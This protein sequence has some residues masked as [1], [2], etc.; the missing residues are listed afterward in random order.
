MTPL[1]PSLLAQ[2]LA[3]PADDAPRVEASDWLQENGEPEFGEFIGVQV[4]IAATESYPGDRWCA[5]AGGKLRVGVEDCRKCRPCLLRHRERELLPRIRTEGVFYA[6]QE[7]FGGGGCSWEY[8]RGFVANLTLACDD[9]MRHAGEIFAAQPVEEVTLSDRWPWVP[10]G[11]TDHAVLWHWQKRSTRAKYVA[12]D[13][14]VPWVLP[15]EIAAHL[16]LRTGDW[17]DHATEADALAA[18]SAACVAHGRASVPALT[19][20][21]T[22]GR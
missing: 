19:A 8:R 9:F 12:N 16:T 21:L 7:R 18:L 22:G 11:S 3:D 13:M 5:D 6:L 4:E 15:D 1:P 2:I 17:T 20:A 10:P 14:N